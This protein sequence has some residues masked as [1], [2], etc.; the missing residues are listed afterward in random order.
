MLSRTI[1]KN[2][3]SLTGYIASSK[4]NTPAPFES[5]LE[6]DLLLLLDFDPTIESYQPQPV[7][8]S[9]S[10]LQGTARKYT[11]DVLITYTQPAKDNQI[12][13]SRPPLLAEVKYR[14]ELK[15][16]WRKLKAKFRATKR[17]ANSKGWRFALLTEYHIRGTYLDNVK[18][19]RKYNNLIH[20]MPDAEILP[21]LQLVTKEATT[22][23]ALIQKLSNNK[24]ERAKYT[25]AL[26][27][28]VARRIVQIDMTT[29]IT[30][31]TRIWR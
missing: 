4:A 20:L 12:E 24:L 19:I 23:A 10:D 6:R 13:E 18:F 3:R 17:W 26:W 7:T 22:P 25:A 9:Y 14:H 8:L 1:P 28:L 31:N 5:S 11:P 2:Y 15:K 30:M 21:V 27:S 16:D 29:P